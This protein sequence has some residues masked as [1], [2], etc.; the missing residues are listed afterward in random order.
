LYILSC[1]GIQESKFFKIWKKRG[2]HPVILAAQEAESR[3]TEVR[4]QLGQTVHEILSILKK[5]PSPKRVV[6]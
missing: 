3:R 6:E 5:N 1:N 4:S 2:A